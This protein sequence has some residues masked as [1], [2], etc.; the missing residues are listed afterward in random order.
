M[1]TV[2][3]ICDSELLPRVQ[4]LPRHMELLDVKRRLHA[5]LYSDPPTGAFEVVILAPTKNKVIDSDQPVENIVGLYLESQ[6]TEI[7]ASYHVHIPTWLV[8]SSDPDV[9]ALAKHL[10]TRAHER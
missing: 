6:Q 9:E 7:E 4:L 2:D 8:R 3:L 1:L 10:K 5:D